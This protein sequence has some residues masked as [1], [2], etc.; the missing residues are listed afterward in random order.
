MAMGTP[1]CVCVCALLS[2]MFAYVSDICVPEQARY[3][4]AC[5]HG[6]RIYKHTEAKKKK[7]TRGRAK[8]IKSA[9]E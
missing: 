3:V 4:Y 9:F 5:V 2:M 6:R 1:V 7:K 8:H